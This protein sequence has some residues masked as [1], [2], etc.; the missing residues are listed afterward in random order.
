[1]N[2]IKEFAMEIFISWSGSRSQQMAEYL[3]EWLPDVFQNISCFLSSE[4]DKGSLWHQTITK[5]LNDCDIGI[6]LVTRGNLNSQWMNYEAGAISK[7]HEASRVYTMILDDSLAIDELGPLSHFQHTKIDEVDVMRLLS[8]LNDSLGD[9]GIPASRF[10]HHLSRYMDEFWETWAGIRHI[11][12]ELPYTD[13]RRMDVK[14]DDMLQRSGDSIKYA[15][16]SLEQ[17]HILGEALGKALDTDV[18]IVTPDTS[19]KTGIRMGMKATIL[20]DGSTAMHGSLPGGGTFKTW[21]AYAIATGRSIE[22]IKKKLDKIAL[23]EN[24]QPNNETK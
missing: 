8:D 6:F 24:S 22:D 16:A 3:H 15:K 17:L 10:E 4:I 11:P 23:I 14:I 21:G 5:K 1:M 19:K 12:L 7:N 9:R 13:N 20:P 2:L 18:R